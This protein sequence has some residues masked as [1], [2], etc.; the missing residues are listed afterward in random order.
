MDDKVIALRK[1]LL[2][3][4]SEDP[5]LR[6]RLLP[7]IK[8]TLKGTLT[9]SQRS[10]LVESIRLVR[11]E[12]MASEFRLAKTAAAVVPTSIDKMPGY[13]PMQLR[14]QVDRLG[15]VQREL[16]IMEERLKAEL[17][18][19]RGLEKEETEGL[20]LLKEAASNM[21]DKGQFIVE[22][23]TALLQFT[24]YS[25]D[26]RPG[27]EQMV[28]KPEDSKWGE[29][30]GDL[31]G[32]IGTKLGEEVSKA[33]EDIYRQCEDDLTHA[34]GAVRGMKIVQKSSSLN[35]AITKSAGISDV[36][37]GLR[38]WFAGKP[39]S[40][41]QRITGFAGDIARWVKGFVV[42]TG[43]VKRDSDAIQTALKN[44]KDQTEKMLAGAL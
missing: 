20:K 13:S 39:N 33:V 42:R 40:I 21:A 1:T 31:F 22:A 28:A 19:I 14:Q 7:I 17:A 27:I 4:A 32:R 6:A 2:H 10:D 18:K 30:A 41:A 12:K 16:A 38:E 8:G 5:A 26:K 11:G 29:K 15:E 44:A 36:L 37:V 35:P 43:L 34:A 23:Q 25:Q 9:A 3:K 24:A